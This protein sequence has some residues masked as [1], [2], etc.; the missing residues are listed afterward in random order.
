MILYKIRENTD[1]YCRYKYR[2]QIYSINKIIYGIN[3]KYNNI[4]IQWYIREPENKLNIRLHKK[5]Q[6]QS[7]IKNIP[8]EYDNII[9]YMFFF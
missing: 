9:S 1:I 6:F 7:F 4:Y 5:S 2:C 8:D 3:F